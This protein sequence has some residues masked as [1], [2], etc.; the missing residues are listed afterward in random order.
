MCVSISVSLCISLS[1][2]VSMC[3]HLYLSVYVSQCVYV[4]QHVCLSASYV[5]QSMHVP[6][7]L[8]VC[9]YTWWLVLC[10][11][12]SFFLFLLVFILTLALCTGVLPPQCVCK[13][14][15]FHIIHWGTMWY[16]IR[17]LMGFT[18]KL[19]ETHLAKII[20]YD[21]KLIHI[22]TVLWKVLFYPIF[23]SI[24]NITRNLPFLKHVNGGLEQLFTY[25]LADT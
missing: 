14:E 8:C 22:Q 13:W 2:Y 7:L 21:M 25:I 11:S 20:F 5:L 6:L 16:S 9:V 1:L 10:V 24:L 3:L 19:E 4:A 17:T 15:P 12:S 18:P 23:F